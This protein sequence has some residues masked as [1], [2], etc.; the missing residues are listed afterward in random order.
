LSESR[1]RITFRDRKVEVAV[2]VEVSG[3]DK[4]KR[5]LSLLFLGNDWHFAERLVVRC[6]YLG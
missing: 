1:F 4:N 3:A 5:L 2:A 6:E